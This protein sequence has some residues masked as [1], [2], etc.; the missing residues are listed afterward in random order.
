MLYIQIKHYR[1]DVLLMERIVGKEREPLGSMCICKCVMEQFDSFS[2]L[3]GKSTNLFTR[4]LRNAPC[5]R[6]RIVLTEGVSASFAIKFKNCNAL[7]FDDSLLS[8]E[9][10]IVSTATLSLFDII[11][12]A[13]S[14]LVP[15]GKASRTPKLISR[16]KS[17]V[18]MESTS[19]FICCNI[20]SQVF[21][22]LGKSELY[23][24]K[25]N[26]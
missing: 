13:S 17:V 16:N 9:S 19:R 24:Y 8:A 7:L 5:D 10:M 20:K 25:S 11:C 21:F 18:I 12:F 15:L 23:T 22:A 14:I 2:I 4:F 1:C 6:T 3:F 26:D